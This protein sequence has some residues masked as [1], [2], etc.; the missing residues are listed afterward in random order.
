MRRKK[1]RN[2]WIQIYNDNIEE[3][4]M[5]NSDKNNA[6]ERKNLI[7]TITTPDD[8]EKMLMPSITGG[9]QNPKVECSSEAFKSP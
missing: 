1:R 3:T 2:Q 7:G 6:E 4:V 8:N 9:D 5:W